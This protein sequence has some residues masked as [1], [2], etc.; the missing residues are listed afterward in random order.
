MTYPLP[1]TTVRP[2]PSGS[3]RA[4][5]LS[6][7]TNLSTDLDTNFAAIRAWAQ[8]A[9]GQLD[10]VTNTTGWLTAGTNWALSTT[11]NSGFDCVSKRV[12]KFVFP[13]FGF[14][15]TGSIVSG[16]AGDVNPDLLMG[17]ITL[18]SLRPVLPT[19]IA[20]EG[21]LNTGLMASAT[22]N[23]DGTIMLTG[24]SAAGTMVNPGFVDSPCW[25]SV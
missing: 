9:R 11:A 10:V 2:G 16:V 17:T 20:F 7:F 12:G 8:S 14:L 25:V 22:V 5:S 15:Y 23:T 6:G 13:T 3:Q 4:G 1:I 24:L 18:V 21:F 19:Q